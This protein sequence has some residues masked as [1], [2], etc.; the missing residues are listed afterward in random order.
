MTSR[1]HGLVM[2]AAFTACAAVAACSAKRPQPAFDP[3]GVGGGTGF[4]C[5]QINDTSFCERSEAEC[6]AFVHDNSDSPSTPCTAR[7][8]ATCFVVLGAESAAGTPIP[9]RSFCSANITDCT[10]LSQSHYRGAEGDRTTACGTI[11]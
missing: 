6:V 4:Y 5:T 10:R 8:E 7:P 1:R 2:V 9:P 3:A 11:R